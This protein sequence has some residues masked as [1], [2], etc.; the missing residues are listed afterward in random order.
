MKAAR[1]LAGITVEQLADRIAA[2]G[3][4]SKTLYNMERGERPITPNDYRVVARACDLPEQFFTF[5]FSRL[6]DPRGD[7]QPAGS[8][9]IER[10]ESRME[11]MEARAAVMAAAAHMRALGAQVRVVGDDTNYSADLFAD[12]PDGRRIAV[13]VK[14]DPSQILQPKNVDRLTGDF[15]VITDGVSFRWLSR[16][17]G[18]D[19]RPASPADL[20][21]SETP[22]DVVAEAEGARPSA[23]TR[24]EDGQGGQQS[25][26]SGRAA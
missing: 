16:D 26:G 6:G 24:P 10:L 9:S 4:G 3:Y 25:P 11:Q 20:S 1:A 23:G 2:R 13:Q 12:L 19:L 18:G 22:E 5:D 8:G 14:A 15:V 21:P 17:A 7:E